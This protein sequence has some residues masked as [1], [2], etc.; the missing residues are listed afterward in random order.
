MLSIIIPTYNNEKYI[1]ECLDSILKQTYNDFEIIIIND[2]SNDNTVNIINEYI[3]KDDRIKLI[4]NSKNL[5][6]GE[7]R[8]I[9]FNESKGEYIWY[10]D[11]DDYIVGDT[12][13][14]NIMFEFNNDDNVDMVSFPYVCQSKKHHGY[15]NKRI[16]CDNIKCK[17]IVHKTDNFATI[18]NRIVKRSLYN[19][20]NMFSGRIINEP[21]IT[22]FK[23]LYYAEKIIVKT[24]N[25]LKGYYF[26]RYNNDSITNNVDEIKMNIFYYVTWLNVYHFLRY[27]KKNDTLFIDF[28]NEKTLD[29]AINDFLKNKKHLHKQMEEKYPNEYNE[30]NKYINDLW[31]F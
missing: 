21:P 24:Y 20:D 14:E 16:V 15:F 10:I 26:Y 25:E 9:G 6:V 30:I 19:K 29:N 8:I 2:Y 12:L 5:G 18:W 3:K 31:N 4:N 22:Y 28:L 13:L 23:L 7:C 1:S 17:T 27:E 11:G